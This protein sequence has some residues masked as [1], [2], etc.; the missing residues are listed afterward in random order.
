[1]FVLVRFFVHTELLVLRKAQKLNTWNT[2][3]Y[4]TRHDTFVRMRA[5][6]P[7]ADVPLSPL[8]KPTLPLSKS[9]IPATSAVNKNL[10]P[11]PLSY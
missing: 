5:V 3:R 4:P 2:M 9:T 6:R 8:K 7:S 10:P 1:M 11:S